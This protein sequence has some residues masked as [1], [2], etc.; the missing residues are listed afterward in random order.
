[1]PGL[2]FPSRPT[3]VPEPNIELSTASSLASTTASNSGSRSR[4]V[5]VGTGST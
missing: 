3:T 4:A 1:M 2:V 5:T